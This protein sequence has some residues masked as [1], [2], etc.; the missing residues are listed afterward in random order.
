MKALACGLLA[1]G[2][3]AAEAT[4]ANAYVCGVGPYRAG[5]V[6]PRGGVVVRRPYYGYYRPYG[7]YHPYGYYRPYGYYGRYCY[8]RAGVR[9]CR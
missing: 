9:I 1:L 6:G 3:L 8:W 2:L 7:Y 5:C 4:E